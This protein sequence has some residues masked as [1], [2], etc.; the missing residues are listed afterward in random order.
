[1]S[2]E[3]SRSDF[4]LIS[5]GSI[6]ILSVPFISLAIELPDLQDLS[7]LVCFD[8]A[9]SKRCIVAAGSEDDASKSFGSSI[10]TV[11]HSQK[12]IANAVAVCV[13]FF[14]CGYLGFLL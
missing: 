12:L 3:S 1:M 11:R 10:L 6:C 5:L 13:F 4:E 2:H 8:A 7:S 9:R 14:V